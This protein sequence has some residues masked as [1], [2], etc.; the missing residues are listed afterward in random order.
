MSNH[1]KTIFLFFAFLAAIV[2][3][4]VAL[5]ANPSIIE[6]QKRQSDDNQLPIVDYDI[7][8]LSNA[9]ILNR[10]RPAI[11]DE[12]GAVEITES[13]SRIERLPA[14]PSAQSD[15]IVIGELLDAHAYL[16]EDNREVYTQY[17]VVVQQVLKNQSS[18][19]ANAGAVFTVKRKGGRVRF[20]S[21]NIQT[22]HLS[23]QGVPRV[24]RRHLLF[25]ER[26]DQISNFLVL[27]A[28]ELNNDRV[29][30]VDDVETQKRY[31]N[32]SEAEFLRVV[33][34]ALT[35]SP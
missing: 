18:F 8:A 11:R 14:I 1:K 22:Y 9:R 16:T 7:S 35:S 32:L 3:M 15:A 13:E 12:N 25:L 5:R 33:Q 17:T 30:P 21:G 4:W 28:Y 6:P 26:S 34:S 23:S 19:D 10:S 20:P 2:T 24:G 27:T 29:F 31:R